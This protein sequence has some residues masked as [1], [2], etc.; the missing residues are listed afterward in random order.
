MGERG[1]KKGK[2]GSIH[3]LAP[4]VLA[5]VFVFLFFLAYLSRGKKCFLR[6]EHTRFGLTRC[7]GDIF[8]GETFQAKLIA[9]FLPINFSYA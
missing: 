2:R 6:I 8:P 9:F 7:P 1:E 4:T 5:L 3:L